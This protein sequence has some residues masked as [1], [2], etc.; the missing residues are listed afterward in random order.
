MNKEWQ[1][2]LDALEKCVKATKLTAYHTKICAEEAEKT[3]NF[4]LLTVHNIEEYL[5]KW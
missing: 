2:Y 3:A 5:K 4:A 1:D